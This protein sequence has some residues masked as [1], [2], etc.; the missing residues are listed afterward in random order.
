VTAGSVEAL[1]TSVLD[2]VL[3]D[4]RESPAGISSNRHAWCC[5]SRRSRTYNFELIH[6]VE[7]TVAAQDGESAD[8]LRIVVWTVAVLG[9]GLR[10]AGMGWLIIVYWYLWLIVTGVHL[11]A[12]LRAIKAAGENVARV[13]P[14]VIASQVL[15]IAAMLLQIEVGDGPVW[16]V[17]AAIVGLDLD[18]ARWGDYD[19]LA[20]WN[21][22]VFVPCVISWGLALRAGAKANT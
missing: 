7:A 11:A 22:L 18:Y 13:R 2:V 17:G 19:D 16:M 9:L 5:R 21:V 15:F 1:V 3:E 8:I 10:V 20:P 12:N 6:R 4:P 14:F